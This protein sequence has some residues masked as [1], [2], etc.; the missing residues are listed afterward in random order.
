MWLSGHIDISRSI[1]LQRKSDSIEVLYRYSAFTQY[2][3]VIEI[4]CHINYA[5]D[6]YIHILHCCNVTN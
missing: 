1:A 5:P 4:Q 3:N 2:Y 6:S